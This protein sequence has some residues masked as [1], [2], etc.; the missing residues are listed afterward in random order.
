MKSNNNFFVA[1][2]VVFIQFVLFG[3]FFFLP[4][5]KKFNLP[6]LFTYVGYF[7]LVL[8]VVVLLI[9][10]FRLG[11]SLSPLP[12]PKNGSELI[13]DGIYGLVR[14]PIY[15]SILMAMFALFLVYGSLTKLII[16]L[17][18]LLF[19]NKKAKFE[20]KELSNKFPTYRNY[21]STTGRFIP[22][23]SNRAIGK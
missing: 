20:E 22:K 14:H 2:F 13:T 18:S 19:F 17:L 3:L 11:R 7:F 23:L 10:I 9:S 6:K 8:S 12:I 15:T 5:I 21:I 4:E 1:W 16:L